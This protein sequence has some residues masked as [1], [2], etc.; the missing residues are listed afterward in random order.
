ME[1]SLLTSSAERW[2]A[3]WGDRPD[4]WAVSEEQQT[5][6]ALAHVSPGDVL[7]ES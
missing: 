1:N 2:G 4:A 5:P 6:E 7:D 3:L